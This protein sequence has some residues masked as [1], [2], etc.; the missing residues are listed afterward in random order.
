MRVQKRSVGVEKRVGWKRQV[1]ALQRA[2]KQPQERALAR[3]E[4]RDLLSD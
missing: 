3:A 4:E 1:H 2:L